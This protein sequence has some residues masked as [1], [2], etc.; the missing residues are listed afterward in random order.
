MSKLWIYNSKNEDSIYLKLLR[1]DY[2]GAEIIVIQS[3]ID[4]YI[5]LTGI[6]INE[7]LKT[8]K[9]I[10]QDNRI[11]TLLKN[12]IIFQVKIMEKY[13]SVNGNCLIFRSV[14]RAKHKFKHRQAEKVNLKFMGTCFFDD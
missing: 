11:R 1:A 14:D 12:D 2:H 6:I 7:S 13:Y 5:G 4:S 3:P 8:F 9:I 10:G